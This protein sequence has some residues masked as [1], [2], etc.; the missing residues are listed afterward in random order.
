MNS[1]ENPS[2]ATIVLVPGHW[3]GAWAW[4]EVADELRA[5]R[6]TVTAVTLPGADPADPDRASRSSADQADALEEV[7]VNTQAETGRSVVLVG[8]SGANHPVG[9]VAS[10]RPDLVARVVWVDSGPIGQGSAFDPESPDGEIER[11]LPE[12]DVLAEGAS[13][14]GLDQ[15]ALQRF[16]E[17]AVPVPGG[18]LRDR[19]ELVGTDH[20][21]LPTTII[22]CSIPSAVML[23]LAGEG[24]PMMAP[25]AELTDLQTVDLPTG[26]WPMWSLPVELAAAISTAASS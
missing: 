20:R 9:V 5:R 15:A 22:A 13:L 26:H 18:V 16:R 3:L 14:D 10:R 7:V 19:A 24:H 6:H 11:A 25:V 1:T 12:F 2:P 8:H 17:R 23:Q 4:D 21:D